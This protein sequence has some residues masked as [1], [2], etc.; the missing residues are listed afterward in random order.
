M[1]NLESA[2]FDYGL[3]RHARRLVP[4]ATRGD[5]YLAEVIVALLEERDGLPD[6]AEPCNT[7][8]MGGGQVA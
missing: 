1:D 4:F 2:T 3:Y 8:L 7:P 6:E 5:R